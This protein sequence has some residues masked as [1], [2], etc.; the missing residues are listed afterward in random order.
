MRDEIPR[1]HTQMLDRADADAMTL[2]VA[3]LFELKSLCLPPARRCIPKLLLD[4]LSVTGIGLE[5]RIL[6][7]NSSLLSEYSLI[8][9][10]QFERLRKL[11][12][13]WR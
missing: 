11:L 9:E 8:V 3:L 2:G 1:N 5:E 13:E 7:L 12:I 4:T 10:Q 6:A